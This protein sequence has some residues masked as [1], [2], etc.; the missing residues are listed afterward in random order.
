LEANFICCNL[1]DSVKLIDEKFDLVFT[2]YGTIGWLPDIN[3]WAKTVAHFMKPGGKFV[4]VEFHPVIWMLDD[5][6]KKIQHRYFN[7]DAIVETLEGN[8]ANKDK[9]MKARFVSWNHGLAE[10]VQALTEAGIR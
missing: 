8:Y 1:Y 10:V 4:F 6:Q 3:Q 5:E 9:E 2:S 7:S